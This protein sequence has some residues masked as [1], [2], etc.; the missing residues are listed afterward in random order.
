VTRR[1]G[2]GEARRPGRAINQA[3]A[4]R[5]GGAARRLDGRRGEAAGRA[6]RRG[7]LDSNGVREM[8]HRMRLTAELWSYGDM[9]GPV[10]RC[11][12]EFIGSYPPDRS[13]IPHP[14]QLLPHPPRLSTRFMLMLHRL[15]GALASRVGSSTVRGPCFLFS[16][17]QY[18]YIA[19][20]ICGARVD[21]AS[22]HLMAC[23][24]P[25]H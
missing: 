10:G 15:L 18:T 13:A 14:S 22:C 25:S 12:F 2:P 19:L 9:S 5:S 17:D 4:A 1:G 24:S 21:G 6:A 7:G 11:P 20:K 16:F 8:Q 3:G 23:V